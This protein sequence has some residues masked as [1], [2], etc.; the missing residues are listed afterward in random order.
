MPLN[1]APTIE[2]GLGLV[3]QKLIRSDMSRA[4][5]CTFALDCGG[6]ASL[7]IAQTAINDFQTNW[8]LNIR[9]HL[10]SQVTCLKP[11]I[12]LGDGSDTPYEA[13]ASGATQVGLVAATFAP[14]NVSLLVKKLTARGGKKNRGRTYLPFSMPT[15]DISE[16]GTVSGGMVGVWQGNFDDFLSQLDTDATPMVIKNQLF[17]TPLPPHFVE[18]VTIGER[19]TSMEVETLIATQR[20][21]LGR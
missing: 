6:A 2:L 12:R 20:R 4:A 18:H 14:P 15:A 9:S 10:D 19:V 21:R 3:T 7:T 8:N 11:T 13:T 5:E 17:D 16:N 1:P